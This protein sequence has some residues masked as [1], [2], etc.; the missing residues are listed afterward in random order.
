MSENGIPASYHPIQKLLQHT[1]QALQFHEEQSNRNGEKF[2]IFNILNIGKK[3]VETHS[4]FLYELLSVNG[5]HEMG[6]TF[7]N[8]FAATV[9]GVDVE[10]Q[11]FKVTREDG[12]GEGRR[13]DFVLESSDYLIGIEMKIDAGDQ[14]KQL[15]DYNEALKKRGVGKTVKLFY[16]TLDGK[17]ASKS[18]L[19][20]LLESQYERVSFHNQIISWISCCIKESAM[21]SV[22]RE[23]L[24]QYQLLLEA[25]TGQRRE[26]EMNLGKELAS[27]KDDLTAALAIEQAVVEAKIIL[28]E[29]FWMRLYEKLEQKE[30]NV[31]VYGGK[32]IKAI[33]VNYYKNSKNNKNIGLRYPIADFQGM[34]IWMYINLYDWVHYGLRITDEN[35]QI[36][37]QGDMKASLSKHF[38]KGNAYCNNDLDW[39][40]CYYND[41]TSEQKRIKFSKVDMPTTLALTNE[42]ETDELLSH[43]VEHL[44]AIENRFLEI[45]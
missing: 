36:F 3:E 32:S 20:G 43:L 9:L 29:R 12:T 34:K 39:V 2:N 31:A 6:D 5:R 37:G 40:V 42:Q 15:Y 28:Q 38:P 1:Y 25:L 14:H 11:V 24:V 35:G 33:A 17:A 13:V 45:K 21:K 4:R 30:R 18:S 10:S 23:A 44:N 41:E 16:L 8:L 27:N 22:L 26:F 7:L 19:N